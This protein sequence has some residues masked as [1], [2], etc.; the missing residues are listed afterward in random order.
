[1]KGV[2]LAGG[3]GTRLHPITRVINKHL[4]PVYDQPMIHYP[5]RCLVGAGID[6]ITIVTNAQHID[7]FRQVLSDGADLGA[8]HLNFAEQRGARGIADALTCAEASVS[9][10]RCC[11]V[12]GDNLFGGDLTGAARRFV[13]QPS[14]AKIMLKPVDDPHRFGIAEL[15]GD[16]L[17]RIVEKPDDPPS[18]LAVTGVYFY[19]GDVFDIC[20]TLAPSER[21]ELEISD[22]NN[23]YLTRGDLTYERLDG[24]W[25]DAGTFEALHAA[26]CRVA[27]RHATPAALGE[28][29]SPTR[30]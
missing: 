3:Q 13:Q 29:A 4:L 10:E 22:V 18:N 19:D 5:I 14:G 15:E 8:R 12:L 2:I 16:R 28:S 21:G 30:R 7:A 11:V 17:V 6:A 25:A 26:S 27:E 1:M 23:H 24:W 9:G 20:R